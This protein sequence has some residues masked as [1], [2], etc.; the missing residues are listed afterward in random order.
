MHKQ[1]CTGQQ[2]CLDYLIRRPKNNAGN[3]VVRMEKTWPPMP[4][5]DGKLLVLHE[6]DRGQTVHITSK[7]AY[8]PIAS[9]TNSDA[10]QFTR[11]DVHQ[12]IQMNTQVAT[13]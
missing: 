10:F 11:Q 4:R 1:Q 5:L 7:R 2:G 3:H 6:P 12:Q 8:N 13:M 9:D